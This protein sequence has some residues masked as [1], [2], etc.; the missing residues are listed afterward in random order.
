MFQSGIVAIIFEPLM[1]FK[2]LQDLEF[3][4]VGQYSLIYDWLLYLLPFE[5]GGAVKSWEE[6]ED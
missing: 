5:P 6:E 1:Q 3:Q 2:I 4:K